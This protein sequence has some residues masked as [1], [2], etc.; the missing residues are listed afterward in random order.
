M[1]S[2]NKTKDQE[3]HG[4]RASIILEA[5]GRPPE[6]LTTTLE[7]LISD[8]DNEKGVKVVSKKLNPPQPTKERKDIFTTFAEVE[9]EVTDIL[10]L[11]VV[12]F[13]FMPAHVEVISPELIALTNNGWTDIL[14]ELTRRLHGYDEVARVMQHQNK[15]MAKKLHD[16]GFLD[17]KGN[18]K[19]K[20]SKK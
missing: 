12:M 7:K 13:K 3:T 18:L 4:I 11:A 19:E 1:S 2:E 5:L 8:I 14:S 16:E 15:L 17:E 10:Y 20:S 6:H 9:I